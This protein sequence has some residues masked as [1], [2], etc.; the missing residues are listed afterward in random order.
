MVYFLYNVNEEIQRAKNLYSGYGVEI[1]EDKR[2]SGLLKQYGT[3]IEESR[4]LMKELGVIE[5][6]SSCADE[7]TGGC[8]YYGVETW[9]S[10][11]LLLINL[12]MGIEIPKTRMFK[13]NCLFVGENGCLLLARFKPC[14]QHLCQK[15]RNTLRQ[16]DFLRL[17]AV[18][19]YEIKLGVQAESAVRDFIQSIR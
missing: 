5:I 14:V 15:I 8:C 2:C 17:R 13:T 12:L 1:L 3:A 19:N 9:Y 7:R 11:Y 16:H 6:C 4:D 10:K 18:T